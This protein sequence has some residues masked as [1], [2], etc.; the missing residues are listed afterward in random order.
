MQKTNNRTTLLDAIKEGH[1]VITPNNRLSMQLHQELL[2]RSTS[3][4]VAQQPRCMP[5]QTF[6]RK[7]FDDSKIERTHVNFPTLLS[8]LQEQILWQSI[9]TK[10]HANKPNDGLLQEISLA[11]TRSQQW[12]LPINKELFAATPQ[13]L[14][15]QQWCASFACVL[16]NLNAISEA[17]LTAYVIANHCL[18][19]AEK[20]IWACFDDFTPEQLSLQRA[21]D[22]KGV[23]QFA[24]DV[25]ASRNQALKYQA[26]D[27]KDELEQIARW[28]EKKIDQN[29]QNIAVIVSDIQNRAD[30]MRRF[31]QQ[32]KIGTQFNISLGKKFIEFPIIAHAISFLELNENNISQ[33]NLKI[34]L[35]S[36]F[37]AATTKE[38]AA[39]S[40]LLED[41]LLMQEETL[42][43]SLVIE[44]LQASSPILAQAIKTMP[45][46]PESATPHEWVVFWQEK[47]NHLGFP[48]DY[49]VNSATYQCFERLKITF[50]EFQSLSI[51]KPTMNQQEAFELLYDLCCKT[52]FQPQISSKP[53]QILGTLEASGVIFDSIWFCGLTDQCMPPKTKLSAFIPI[54][55]QK[56]HNMPRALPEREWMLANILINRTKASACEVIFSY[57]KMSG[58][59]PNLPSPLIN[60]L[61]MYQALKIDTIHQQKFLQKVD[62]NYQIALSEGEKLAGGTTL[63][64][65]QAQC[66]FKAMAAHR[67]H[68]RQQPKPSVG[69][70]AAEKGQI[71]HR[72]M[73]LVWQKIKNQEKLIQ[74]SQQELDLII[75]TAINKALLP[76]RAQKRPSMP[77]IVFKIEQDRLFNLIMHAIS[78][79]KL[80]PPFRVLETEASHSICIANIELRLRVDRVDC[81]IEDGNKWVI[82][83]KSQ[84]PANKPWN[85]QRPEQ[86]QLILYSMLDEK[87]NALLF[88]QLKTGQIIASGISENSVKIS[89]VNKTK[90]SWAYMQ[91]NWQQQIENLAHE[92]SQGLC[93]PEPQR[94]STC[95]SCDFI[96]LCRR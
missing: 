67:L 7:L 27:N 5:Y 37:L 16:K 84:I 82:D 21:L 90:D 86:P 62:E 51:I 28:L 81:A 18:P 57:P 12:Q 19:Q 89:G 9:I 41:E 8:N 43:A 73:E 6:I 70:N 31:F 66:P 29:Q 3:F 42:Q 60:D 53:I 47:L 35:H 91:K 79:E 78:W 95:A 20:I 68:A 39:R 17:Q 75:E 92:L 32:S 59:T 48:G 52:I 88:L 1:T 13:T 93:K 15:F 36:P 69:L 56:K 40:G 33:L 74:C 38:F 44:K 63:L 64:A 55:L 45:T 83:Y 4:V 54:E 26:I 30:S 49:P 80:R 94:A 2:A 58:D 25:N 71:A 85:E 22:D 87:I 34:L 76:F 96:D 77:N 50:D 23:K 65:N 46:A 14:Q 24:Y 61:Q 10:N 72:I 11:W